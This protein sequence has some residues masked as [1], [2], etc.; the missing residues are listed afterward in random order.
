MGHT[1]ISIWLSESVENEILALPSQDILPFKDFWYILIG[2][3]KRLYPPFFLTIMSLRKIISICKTCIKK[4]VLRKNLHTC[5]FIAQQNKRGLIKGMR[6]VHAKNSLE[7]IFF[8]PSILISKNVIF[9]AYFLIHFFL[10][11]SIIIS[12]LF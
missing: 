5:D 9:V 6:T 1:S 4:L 12:K 8:V 2:F 7:K 11:S 3:F 10:L